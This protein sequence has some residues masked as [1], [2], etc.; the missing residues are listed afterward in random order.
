MDF[1]ACSA[2]R[3]GSLEKGYVELVDGGGHFV[4]GGQGR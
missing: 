4:C 1:F 2:N 3:L